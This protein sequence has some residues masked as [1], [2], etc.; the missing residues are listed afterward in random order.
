MALTILGGSDAQ[1]GDAD[2][3]AI[4]LRVRFKEIGTVPFAA[5]ANDVEE[6]GRLIYQQAV[7]GQFGAIASYPKSPAQVLADQKAELQTKVDQKAEAIR[8]TYLTTGSGQAMVYQR[9]SEEATR[10]Q[11]DENPDPANYPILSATVGIEGATIQEVAALVIATTNA[12][13]PIAAAIETARLG[14]KA[15]IEAAA[16]L[17][18][19]N[20]AF[21][22]IQWPP[23]YSG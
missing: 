3:T 18:D 8:N 22:A 15:K 14:G 10:L 9:K 4:L 23:S 17:N 6:H 16:S 7:A 2:H 19:A 21:D 5:M 13:L 12:W 11:T 20:V 1:W